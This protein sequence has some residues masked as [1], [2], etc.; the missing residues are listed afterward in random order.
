MAVDGGAV[1]GLVT[2][3]WTRVKASRIRSHAEDHRL[4]TAVIVSSIR[5]PRARSFTATVERVG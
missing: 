1:G 5:A 4:R 3:P 2:R